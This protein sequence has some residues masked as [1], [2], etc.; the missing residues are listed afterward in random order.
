MQVIRLP[1]I[2]WTR[3]DD[4]LFVEP[5][6]IHVSIVW[7]RSKHPKHTFTCSPVTLLTYLA[8]QLRRHQGM[9][10]ENPEHLLLT[11]GGGNNTMSAELADSPNLYPHVASF[12][13]DSN[14]ISGPQI[15][16][17][18]AT[19]SLLSGHVQHFLVIAARIL[20]VKDKIIKMRTKP[21]FHS[22][23]ITGSIRGNRK[24][25]KKR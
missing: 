6:T 25:K 18:N 20:D 11:R 19:T 15:G 4:M 17:A 13:H 7:W 24:L 16:F 8:Q 22:Y 3:A 1:G 21:N 9:L 5:C 10:C 2:S 14:L 12:A 23:S